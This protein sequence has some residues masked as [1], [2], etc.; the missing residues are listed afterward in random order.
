M[1]NETSARAFRLDHMSPVNAGQWTG[2][3]QLCSVSC[4]Y[5]FQGQVQATSLSQ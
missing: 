2:A 1:N 5:V 3:I 4:P